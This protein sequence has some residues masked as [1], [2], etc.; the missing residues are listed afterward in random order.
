MPGHTAQSWWWMGHVIVENMIGLLLGFA[1]ER[2]RR[3]ADGS[4]RYQADLCGLFECLRLYLQVV[5]H[6][7]TPAC[8]Q[9]SQHRLQGSRLG[10]RGWH[11][12]IPAIISTSWSG[13][14]N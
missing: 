2:S 13:G 7:A 4:R 1:R 11:W 10:R 12:P 9:L 14:G 6:A 3:K 5:F 8:D